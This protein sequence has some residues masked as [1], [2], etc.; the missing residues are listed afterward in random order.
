MT[1]QI[2]IA[3][4]P[5]LGVDA[6][7]LLA[8]WNGDGALAELGV[9]G[10]TAVSPRHFHDPS[11]IHLVLEAS[12]GIAVGVITSQITDLLKSTYNKKTQVIEQT[13]ADGN[14]IIVI[15]KEQ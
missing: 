3:L 14:K 13:S 11:L 8:A 5:S 2:Q 4:D 10:K 12:I 1:Q 9:M 7:T 6:E 15:I